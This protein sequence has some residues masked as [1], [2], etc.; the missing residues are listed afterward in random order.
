MTGRRIQ[1]DVQLLA[2]KAVRGPLSERKAAVRELELI[3]RKSINQII[4]LTNSRDPEVRRE[5]AD[6][7]SRIGNESGIPCLID[8]MEDPE[9]EVRWRASESLVTMGR[10]TVVP[11]LEELLKHERFGSPRFLD[12]V[13]HV[14]RRMNDKG[15]L[16]PSFEVL[17]ALE[18]PYRED[19]V[20]W[21]AERALDIL[22]RRPKY[23]VQEY[24]HL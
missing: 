16:G 9:L 23:L 10:A 5:A 11:L 14:L 21:A 19:T 1:P 2:S 8:L 17:D 18:G 20:P 3:G 22:V 12:G 4:S 13:H 24:A 7:L 6:L 15:I